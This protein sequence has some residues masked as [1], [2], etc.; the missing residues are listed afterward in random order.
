MIVAQICIM[1]AVLYQF[2]VV[3][4]LEMTC[5][6]TEYS[7]LNKMAFFTEYIPIKSDFTLYHTDV[8]SHTVTFRQIWMVTHDII[9]FMGLF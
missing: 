6:V 2:F 9:N 5:W 1:Q 8:D 7:L 4:G 3:A